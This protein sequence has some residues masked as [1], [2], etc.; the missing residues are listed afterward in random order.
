MPKTAKRI[1]TMGLGVVLTITMV[2]NLTSFGLKVKATDLMEGIKS[3]N[4]TGKS[5]DERFIGTT[6]DFSIELFKKS[7]GEKNTLVSP[8]SVMLALAMTANGADKATLAQM[9]KVLGNGMSIDELNEYLYS[10]AKSLP[11]KKKSKFNIS[12]SI[13]FREGFHVE[14]DFLQKNANYYK[15]AAYRSAFDDQTMKDI[16]NWVKDKTDGMIDEILKKISP[17]AVMYLI[18]AIVFDAEWMEVYESIDISEGSFKNL[19]GTNKKV[20]MMSSTESGYIKEDNALGFIK[21]YK[22]GDY[23]FVA[24]L[25]DE[26]VDFHDYISTL[27][28]ETFINIIESAQKKLVRATL[29]KFSYEYEIQMN[30]IL[31]DM[32]MVDAFDEGKADLSRI[33]G[34]KSNLVI[35]E[36]LHK[37]FISVDEKGT[38]AG[39]VTKVEVSV[40]SAPQVEYVTL[41]RPFIY[42]IVDNSTNLPIFLGAVTN[43]G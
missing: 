12:N 28:G 31:R 38:K 23:S 9:E 2:I 22:N 17:E 19:D 27:T 25:P 30:D 40:T 26:D 10:Y 6:A 4:V 3:G 13:W 8:L 29:P 18:N 21:P 35:S 41:D 42:A 20:E 1:L 36:V 7:V 16:N 37:T 11:N 43:L 32:G 5:I 34:S 24:L 14:E 33:S 39:A 15:A